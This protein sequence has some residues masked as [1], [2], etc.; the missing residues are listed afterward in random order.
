MS[1]L[2]RTVGRIV[3]SWRTLGEWAE[4]YLPLLDTRQITQKTLVNRH[5]HVRRI[6]KA[7]GDRRIGTI[8]PHEIN[9][10]IAEV[11]REHP[12]AAKRTL[13]EIR[14][15]LEEA[16]AN[17]WIQTNP[18]KTVRMPRVS[19]RR[20]RLSLQEWVRIEVYA[21][22]NSP[23]WVCRMLRLALVTGQRRSDLVKMRFS[24]VWPH[25]DGQEY[26]HVVQAKTGARL[27]IPL[28]LRLEAVRFSADDERGL[29]VR[30]V[31]ED[32]RS[33]SKIGDGHF[34]R[35]TTGAPPGPESMSWRFEQAR[36]AVLPPEMG[37]LQPPTLH[38]CRS[39][40]AREYRKQGINTQD[41]LG[42]SKQ[43][44]T[45]LYHD[46]RGLDAREGKWRVVSLPPPPATP[47]KDA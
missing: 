16:V 22:G 12:V 20:R 13:I 11:G 46:D 37:Q 44:M 31:I 27:A 30:D 23:P 10:L 36:E 7:F 4:V 47:D 15:M 2:S 25:D 34:L 29:S 18:G 26:L 42:H 41:L 6:V 21:R 32:C 28:D 3:P 35:K 8:R 33:Y 38:E 40:A 45:E 24:D 14:A 17:G 39:L 5:A 43:A 19:V 1:L 9:A